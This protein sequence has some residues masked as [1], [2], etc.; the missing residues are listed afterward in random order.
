[1]SYVEFAKNPDATPPMNPM[2]SVIG[3]LTALLVGLFVSVPAGGVLAVGTALYVA[4][5]MK[6]DAHDALDTG[7]YDRARELMMRAED[8]ERDGFS[9][10]DDEAPPPIDR[11]PA[12]LHKK[13]RVTRLVDCSSSDEEPPPPM[14]EDTDTSTGSAT[15]GIDVKALE[16]L[17]KTMSLDEPADPPTEQGNA[18]AGSSV[19]VV[20]DDFTADEMIRPLV[21]LESFRT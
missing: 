8:L 12:I 9:S 2:A 6:V 17:V 18:A 10:S 13:I 7:E 11:V 3:S 15:S 4:R 20:E 16:A 1:M 5:Q 19:D 14:N 21:L